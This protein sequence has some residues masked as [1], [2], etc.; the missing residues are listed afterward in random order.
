MI[1]K[2]LKKLS[3]RYKKSNIILGKRPN[4]ANAKDEKNARLFSYFE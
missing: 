3:A 4:N 1:Q 2:W